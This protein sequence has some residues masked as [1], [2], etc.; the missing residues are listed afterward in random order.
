MIVPSVLRIPYLL[1][2]TIRTL[3]GVLVSMLAN[4][5]G[6]RG[7]AHRLACTGEASMGGRIGNKADRHAVGLSFGGVFS[8]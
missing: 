4:G 1:R 5:Q 3:C 7:L 8:G 2:H 6:G